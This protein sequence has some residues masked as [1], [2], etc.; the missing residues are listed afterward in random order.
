LNIT[1]F[2]ITDVG[3]HYIGLRVLATMPFASRDGQN[4]LISRNV[5]KYARDKA[6]RLMLP[7]P[8]STYET[9]GE[10]ICQELAHFGFAEPAKGRGYELTDEGKRV[11]ALLNQKKHGELRRLM[12][13][14]HLKTYANLRTVVHRHITQTAIYSPTVETANVGDL[15]YVAGLLR[16]TFG[17][18]ASAE[19]KTLIDELKEKSA[20]KIENALRQRVLDHVFHDALSISVPIFRSM[21]DRLITLRLL[22]VMKATVDDCEFARS[23]SPCGESKPMRP[24]HNR[25]EVPFG[26]GETY[27][28]F[29]SEPNMESPEVL[30]ELVAALDVAFSTLQDQAGYFDLPDV[31][32]VVC[33]K[34]LIPESTFDEG[35]NALLDATP[36]SVTVGLTYERVS[37]R[38]K[39]LVR[40][41]DSI[42]LFNLIR[43]T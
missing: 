10:K 21:C 7:E 32:D 15:R 38:R 25:V 24:W 34:L 4:D 30:A 17:E 20:K 3:Y 8:R 35:I 2:N 11:L 40:G 1:S 9:V 31:R 19:A 26:S 27:V 42:Q 18:S 29:L 23:Y 33:E 28:I 37:A 22:N 5:L 6:L 14:V 36:A 12:A 39:P 13:I 41:R 43:R 16:P